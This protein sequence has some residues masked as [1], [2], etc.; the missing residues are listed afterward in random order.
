VILAGH[1][2]T[3]CQQK[4]ERTPRWDG[5]MKSKMESNPLNT[6]GGLQ[7]NWKTYEKCLLSRLYEIIKRSLGSVCPGA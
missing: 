4:V 5:E 7:Q 1:Y 2:P 3:Y 6:S